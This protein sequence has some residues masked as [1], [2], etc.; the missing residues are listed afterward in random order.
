M[1]GICARFYKNRTFVFRE[2]TT[3]V[4]NEQMD[5]PTNEYQ[6]TNKHA[7]SQYLL[8]P[9]AL[10]SL[11]KDDDTNLLL[12]AGFVMDRVSTLVTS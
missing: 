11:W 4:M 2:I 6:Q 7:R 1:I 5:E 3:S 9:L 8:A 10:A 12:F